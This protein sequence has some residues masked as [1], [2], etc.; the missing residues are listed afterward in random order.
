M[1][2]YDIYRPTTIDDMEG[3]FSALSL[4]LKNPKHNHT[5]LF[6][7]NFGTGKTTLARILA[8]TVGGNDNTIIEV[9]CGADTGVDNLRDILYR[10]R[11]APFLIGT[12][13]VIILDELHKL[14][15]AAQNLLLKETETVPSHLYWVLSTSESSGI[16]RGLITRALPVTFP[17]L[18]HDQLLHAINRVISLEGGFVSKSVKEEIITRSA[19]SA[20]DAINLL[21]LVIHADE[22]QQKEIILTAPRTS[23]DSPELSSFAYVFWQKATPQQLRA[24]LAK[25]KAFTKDYEGVR[26][27]LLNYGISVWLNSGSDGVIAACDILRGS[28]YTNGFADFACMC[29]NAASVLKSTRTETF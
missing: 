14:S 13:W 3:D 4:A 1:S 11:E 19:G 24:E 5:F 7:G 29:Y 10:V 27:A 2:L 15:S 22:E 23:G 8:K 18:S 17:D 21:E 25:I 28:T 12:T 9:N 16:L 6:T 20:R 26:R